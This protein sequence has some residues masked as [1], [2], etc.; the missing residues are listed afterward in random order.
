MTYA[1]KAVKRDM[2]IIR[3]HDYLRKPWK[4]GLGT[5]REIASRLTGQD[6]VWRLSLARVDRDG[7]FSN[8]AGFDRI[9]TVVEGDGMR[10]SS[11]DATF[12]ARPFMPVRFPGHL[13]ITGQCLSTPIENF[14][15]IF[16]PNRVQA[17]MT[18]ASGP[19]IR[20]LAGDSG[21]TTILHLREGH[22]SVANGIQLGTE[23]SC[24]CEG[25]LPAFEASENACCAL[26]SLT[27]R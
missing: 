13:E 16:D 22:V 14:N 5:T 23:D 24:I 12:E 17:D 3:S 11:R 10:L 25:A 20:H 15:L 1:H 9:L 6:M 18:I 4:N 19:A 8:F 21:G 26:V 2:Q 27:P 7:P